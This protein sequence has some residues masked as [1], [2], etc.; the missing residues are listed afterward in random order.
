MSQL[1]KPITSLDEVALKETLCCYVLERHEV[2]MRSVLAADD[3]EEHYAVNINA[4]SM[5]ERCMEIC[6]VLITSPLVLLPAF[7]SALVHAQTL[8]LDQLS[9]KNGHS[10][11]ANVHARIT[12]LPVQP[13]FTRSTVPKT[14]DIGNFLALTGTVIRTTVVKVL[15]YERD[16]IC[17]KCKAVITQKA[18]V[19]QYSSVGR[20]ARCVNDVCNSTSFTPLSDNSGQPVKCQNYQE[21]K[22]QEQVQRL[23]MGTIPR[24]MW[25]ILENDLVDSC[26]AGDD[27]VI[28]GVVMRRWRGLAGEVKCDIELAVKA[29]SILVT[30]EMRSA[31][32][33]TQELRDEVAEFWQEHE[34]SPLTGRNVILASLCPQVYG[35]YVIKLA[36]AMVLA[37]GVKREDE[38]GT[39]V[40]GEIHMLLV[41]D[42]GTGKSQFLKYATKVTPRSV[43]TTGIGSTSAGL[44]VTAVKD[45]GEWQL[46]AGAL[47]LADGGLCCIDEFNSIREHDK[48]SIHEAMEQQT[49]SV[50]KAGMVCK[51]STRTTI[52]AATNPKGQYDPNESLSVNIALASPLLSRFD[53]VLVLLD[54]QNEDWDRVVSDYILLGK[55]PAHIEGDKPPLTWSMEKMQGYISLIKT[56]SPELTP[57]ATR[58]LRQ[59]Y[60]AQRG[61]DDRNAARTTMRLLQSIIRLAQAHAR[62]MLRVHVSVQ[63]AVVAVTLMES[64]MQGSALLGGVNALHTAF[65]DNPEQEYRVQA[66]LILERLGCPDLLEE[67][68][69]AIDELEKVHH[70][71]DANSAVTNHTGE[72]GSQPDQVEV[73]DL[74]TVKGT[75]L[76]EAVTGNEQTVKTLDSKSNGVYGFLTPHADGK[77]T[78][79]GM[80]PQNDLNVTNVS[81]S[82]ILE[83]SNESSHENV[84]DGAHEFPKI[85]PSLGEISQSQKSISIHS[86]NVLPSNASTP[87]R[88]S[89]Q[90]AGDAAVV[91]EPGV[92]TNVN[93]GK[94]L[95]RQTIENRLTQVQSRETLKSP[96]EELLD[97]SNIDLRNVQKLVCIKKPTSK[98]LGGF[99]K[100]KGKTKHLTKKLNRREDTGNHEG[101]ECEGQN[102]NHEGK[103]CE[104]QNGNHEGK[105]C[106]G[107][108]GNHEGKECE[109]Q[110][111]NHEGKEC[112]GQNGN[113]EGKECEGQNGNHEGKECEGQ[114]GKKN[115]E[116]KKRAVISDS[117]D[118]CINVQNTKRSRSD[119][120]QTVDTNKRCSGDSKTSVLSL[121]GGVSK[122]TLSKLKQFQFDESKS[123]FINNPTTDIG[124][125]ESI[126]SGSMW[127]DED[128]KLGRSETSLT[129]TDDL[130][131][132]MNNTKGISGISKKQHINNE[133]DISRSKSGSGPA[134]LLSLKKKFSPQSQG[135]K[136]LIRP[137]CELQTFKPQSGIQVSAG[138][139]IQP[140]TSHASVAGKGTLFSIN[141]EL[142]FDD[143]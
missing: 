19:E 68:M 107:Q 64:S 141:D 61:S 93:N 111:G 56:L 39:C 1:F 58:V 87:V 105:E 127:V 21:I 74:D 114:N 57:G 70:E 28:C 5:F 130:V 89:V 106:E 22:V 98:K 137:S 34:F 29:N 104:G 94:S 49:I 62:L 60:H 96:E 102:G 6:P 86:F 37:G 110:N 72:R 83:S 9:D 10:V 4:L 14:S 54:T 36:V 85:V 71:K 76:P 50:A 81:L 15:E 40:R 43:L 80:H 33:I 47:V 126:L 45:S 2:D 8:L 109:G 122:S 63:D 25:I 13:E 18:D 138:G 59:Y 121:H 128:D 135:V 77:Q 30:N 88:K 133:N 132:E 23:V 129:D 24:S 123:S 16:Y 101:K 103:E 95:I 119:T 120:N 113:H 92:E 3:Q 125:S 7:D 46:E 131:S 44:T 97:T 38:G 11:K 112:E 139:C 124:L 17:A 100:I 69:K 51:L 65:P 140:N 35:L 99:I 41:G 82:D 118:D 27:V 66:Q 90:N 20:P 136:T 84:M 134:W 117:D 67:E 42:P 143:L 48:A 142:D 78:N 108:N 32:T 53:L 52:L 73:I 55:H 116:K 26:K 75:K 12:S 31:S 91:L 115:T 79:N